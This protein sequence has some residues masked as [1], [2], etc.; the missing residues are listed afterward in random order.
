MIKNNTT[1]A[2]FYTKLLIECKQKHATLTLA[3]LSMLGTED[4]DNRYAIQY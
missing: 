2:T 1:N 3:M 4:I